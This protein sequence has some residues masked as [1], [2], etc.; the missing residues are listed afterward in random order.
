[1]GK[2]E[3][4]YIKEFV[5]H[6]RKLWYDHIF[7]YDN[8]NINGERIEDIVQQ[9]INEGFI[10]LINLRGYRGKKNSFTWCILS[11]LWK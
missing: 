6:Y 3:N 4:L 7:I 8:N 1:M 10:S 11:L 9:E 2:N 5:N